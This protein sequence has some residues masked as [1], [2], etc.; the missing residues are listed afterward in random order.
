MPQIRVTS[1]H[2][3]ELEVVLPMASHPAGRVR[4]REHAGTGFSV[5]CSSERRHPRHCT[6]ITCGCWPPTP[7]PLK[8][9][10]CRFQCVMEGA[11]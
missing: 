11:G 3:L 10:P 2:V 8:W 5:V 1:N 4:W 7:G 9:L 6:A